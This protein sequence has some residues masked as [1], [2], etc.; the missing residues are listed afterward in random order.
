MNNNINCIKKVDN[1]GN[2]LKIKIHVVPGSSKSI[3][4]AGYNKWRK[5]L[6]IRVKSKAIENKANIEVIE[7][8]SLFFQIPPKNISIVSGK[9][10]RDKVI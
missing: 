1:S 4:P 9:K 10:S 6:E 8:I 2:K 5:S 7:K 3:F